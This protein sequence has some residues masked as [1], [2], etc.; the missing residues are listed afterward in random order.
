MTIRQIELRFGLPANVSRPLQ[1]PDGRGGYFNNGSYLFRTIT[2]RL[3]NG[4]YM[5][6][7][8]KQPHLG[9]FQHCYTEGVS[10]KYSADWEY[11]GPPKAK[12]TDTPF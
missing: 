7:D 10:E 9:E 2:R 6:V 1:S 8:E 12:E 4:H 11:L 5:Q 3:E